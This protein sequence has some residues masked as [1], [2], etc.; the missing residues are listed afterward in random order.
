MKKFAI[1]SLIYTAAIATALSAANAGNRPLLRHSQALEMKNPLWLKIQYNF[2]CFASG[3]TD[4]SNDIVIINKSTATV[5]A[6]TKVY[7]Q[8]V[9]LPGSGVKILPQLAPG[10]GVGIHNAF[11]KTANNGHPCTVKTL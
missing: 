6:G 2:A 1:S 8:M 5:P 4:F 10:K 11:K 7:W 3:G 9:G